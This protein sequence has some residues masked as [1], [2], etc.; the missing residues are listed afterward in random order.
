MNHYGL[1]Y[2]PGSPRYIL[3]THYASGTVLT[4]VRMFSFNP[5][6]SLRQKYYHPHLQV[7]ILSSEK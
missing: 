7:R 1:S 2:S 3:S 4:A 5:P 6:G